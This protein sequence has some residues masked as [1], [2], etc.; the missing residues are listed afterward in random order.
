MNEEEMYR[1]ATF[2]I[3]L[4]PQI[5]STDAFSATYPARYQNFILPVTAT[6][7]S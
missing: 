3:Q 1:G 2:V 7:E 4:Y 6:H 5:A